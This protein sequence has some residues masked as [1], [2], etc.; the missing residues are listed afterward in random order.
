M[1]D[2]NIEFENFI[3]YTLNDAIEVLTKKNSE[4]A[5]WKERF[6]E[7]GAKVREIIDKLPEDEK[8]IM[9]TYESN[10]I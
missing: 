5:E 1:S 4:Y 6:Q 3:N 8:E 10:L 9:N 2:F 7:N